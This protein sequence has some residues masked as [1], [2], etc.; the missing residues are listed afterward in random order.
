MY[1]VLLTDQVNFTKTKEKFCRLF[2]C[3]I[4]ES[5][6]LN[7]DKINLYSSIYAIPYQLMCECYI[8]VH[9]LGRREYL[10]LQSTLEMSDKTLCQ[11]LITSKY[12][13]VLANSNKKNSYK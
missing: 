5:F 3:L 12:T 10:L 8:V 13:W 2:H 1:I 9:D 11:I 7:E 6:I 4:N